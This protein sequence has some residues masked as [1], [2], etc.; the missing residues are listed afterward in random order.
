MSSV[1]HIQCRLRERTERSGNFYEESNQCKNI[2]CGYSKEFNLNL[3][4]QSLQSDILLKVAGT[5]GVNPPTACLPF[6]GF[7]YM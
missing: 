7:S 2:Y 3:S 6:P 4:V 5:S 1:S